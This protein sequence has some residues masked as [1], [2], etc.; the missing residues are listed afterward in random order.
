[1]P[2]SMSNPSQSVSR[3]QFQRAPKPKPNESHKVNIENLR[4]PKTYAVIS[5]TPN[6]THTQILSKFGG[7]P[8]EK[9]QKKHADGIGN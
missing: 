3:F 2:A 4:A 6:I 7:T 9:E 1:M 8:V 5:Y